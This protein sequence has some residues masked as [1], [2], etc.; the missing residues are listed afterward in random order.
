[1]DEW[2]GMMMMGERRPVGRRGEEG[3][4]THTHKILTVSAGESGFY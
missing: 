3:R 2:N 4:Y 1:M